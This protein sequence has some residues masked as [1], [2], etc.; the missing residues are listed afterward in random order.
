MFRMANI[1][2]KCIQT[3][4]HPSVFISFKASLKVKICLLN[5]IL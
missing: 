3:L 1:K 5:Y 4:I 2:M